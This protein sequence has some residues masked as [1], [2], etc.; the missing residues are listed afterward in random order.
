MEECFTAHTP[1]QA[2][3]LLSMRTAAVL[4]ALQGEARS[5]AEVARAVEEPL[6][7]VHRTLGQLVEANLA[8]M[9]GLRARHGR[10]C[11]L[12]MARAAEYEVPFALT[13]AATV[14]ELM[15]AQ[16]RPFFEGFVRHQ[17]RL[18]N[19]QGRDTLRLELPG[20]QPSYSVRGSS[21]Q[22]LSQAYGLFA[23]LRLTRA[24]AAALQAEL[25]A[26]GEQYSRSSDHGPPYLLGLLLVPGELEP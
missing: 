7:G 18:L 25:R 6:S 10:P 22:G 21:G 23:A 13:D 2:R 16:Y 9:V 12:Y 14:Q 11:K 5:A 15:A 20:G 24:Q 17:A 26:L 3:L 8:R 4:G 1:A 19:E